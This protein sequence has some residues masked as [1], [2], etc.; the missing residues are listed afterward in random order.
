MYAITGITGQ[1]GSAL[2]NHL[3][4]QGATV[5]A[6]VRNPA[7]AQPWAIRGCDLAVADLAD[8]EALAKAFS[9]AEGVF[10]LIPPN[11]DPS[12]GF[13]DLYPVIGSLV[14]AIGIARPSKVVLLSTIG[15]QAQEPNLL[16][17][18]GLVE[19]AFGHLPVPVAFLRAAWFMENAAWDVAGARDEG[20]LH[21][22]LQPLDKP[23]PMVA[24][25]DIAALAA[26]LLHDTWQ[27]VRI[28]E[29]EGPRRVSPDDLARALGHAVGREVSPAAV[30]RGAWETTFAM[31]GM[32]YPVPRARMID[33]FNEEWIAFEGTGTHVR[34]GTTQVQA[35]VDALVATAGQG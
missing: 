11:F 33:G 27:G 12:P 6:V 7:K 30:P 10:V 14:R 34:K 23:V 9:G 21:S 3:L 28:V 24:T 18:L 35:V 20:V 19:H 16:S 26:E 4:D 17:Q 22:F 15:A 25:R 8:S 29:L 2:A 1:V 31:Q 32:Q 5:R 13:P